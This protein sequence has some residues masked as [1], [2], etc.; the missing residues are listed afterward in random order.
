MS[1]QGA[2]SPP[3][4]NG[5]GRELNRP[6]L[7]RDQGTASGF[8]RG[9]SGK[10]RHQ[11]Q[12]ATRGIFPRSPKGLG[13]LTYFKR[14]MAMYS[15]K[16]CT[17]RRPDAVQQKNRGMLN[18]HKAISKS[19]ASLPSRHQRNGTGR[20]GKLEHPWN[21]LVNSPEEPLLNDCQE[22]GPNHKEYQNQDPHHAT[23]GGS[24]GTHGATGWEGGE[25][26][27]LTIEATPALCPGL[28]PQ[29]MHRVILKIIQG[30]SRRDRTEVTANS[31]QVGQSGQ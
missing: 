29:R 27:P 13:T 8:R 18:R 25:R 9:P 2:A 12:K 31:R 21:V 1:S 5:C 7:Y 6:S 19:E 15:T 28:T 22:E 16:T 20:K 30:K 24:T 17:I 4:P 10:F 26:A 11:P 23:I 14:P 3:L